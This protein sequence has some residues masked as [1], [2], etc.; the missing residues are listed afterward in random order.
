[1]NWYGAGE[2]L[3]AE[4]GEGAWER[5][6]CSRAWCLKIRTRG[7]APPYLSSRTRLQNEY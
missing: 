1:M 2:C 3:R 5:A 6:V 7:Q 4:G